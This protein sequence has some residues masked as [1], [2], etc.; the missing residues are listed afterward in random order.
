MTSEWDGTAWG[1]TAVSRTEFTVP[2]DGMAMVKAATGWQNIYN[3]VNQPLRSVNQSPSAMMR[4][5]QGLYHVHPWIRRAEATVTGK[6]AN[7]PWHLEDEN[8]DEVDD[9]TTNPALESIQQLLEKPQDALPPGERQPGINTWRGLISIT[10]R[11][12]GLCGPSYWFLDQM[13]QGGLPLALLYL[14]PARIQ[15]AVN[16]NGNVDGT[17]VY[18][19]SGRPNF[20]PQATLETALGLQADGALAPLMTA[21][22]VTFAAL[23]FCCFEAWKL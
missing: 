4:E 23:V 6:V 7:L 19:R 10:S 13:D 3:G 14:N 8:D 5:A 21:F 12:M 17:C 9:E 2:R 11:H 18:C 22:V 15:P 20:C 1:G 16:P